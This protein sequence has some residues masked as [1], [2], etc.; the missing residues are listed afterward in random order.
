MNRIENNW[1]K[2]NEGRLEAETRKW[3]ETKIFWFEDFEEKNWS[4]KIFG[5]VYFFLVRNFI[6]SVGN[7]GLRD[8]S[9]DNN[10]DQWH[11]TNFI[12]EPNTSLMV[13]KPHWAKKGGSLLWNSWCSWHINAAYWH[14]VDQVDSGGSSSCWVASCRMVLWWTTKALVSSSEMTLSLRLL[15][16]MSGN[17]QQRRVVGRPI[18]WGTHRRRAELTYWVNILKLTLLIIGRDNTR[19]AN[20]LTE[21]LISIRQGQFL[22][23]DLKSKTNTYCVPGS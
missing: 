6:P 9:S 17:K 22:R 10:S 20:I 4:T 16:I 15:H 13:F 14:I 7:L 21:F 19:K 2:I 18:V 8:Y 11:L 1:K 5:V 12:S 23:L 3:E